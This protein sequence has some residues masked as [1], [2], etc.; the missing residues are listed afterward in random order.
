[1]SHPKDNVSILHGSLHLQA[2]LETGRHRLLAEDVV[3]LLCERKHDLQVHLVLDCHD[4][5]VGEPLSNEL[6]GLL[7][8]IE[9]FLPCAED[10][11]GVHIVC[12]YKVLSRVWPWFG[13]SDDLANSWFLES[14]LCVRLPRAS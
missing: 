8:G 12:L 7:R 2:I 3:P 6:H 10:E 14:I 1:M 4:D 11:G 13:D 5:G 9:E